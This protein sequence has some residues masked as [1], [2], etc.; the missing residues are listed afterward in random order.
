M[1]LSAYSLASGSSGNS[2]LVCNEET[3]ILIDAGLSGRELIL[4]MKSIGFDPQKL[5]AILIS[6]EHLDHIHGAGPLARKLKVPIVANAA[7]LS[8]MHS[9]IGE[10]DTIQQRTGSMVDL[11]G[12]LVK[13]FSIP[14]DAA[15]PVGFRFERGKDL[16]CSA[17]DIG[18]PTETLFRAM[19]GCQLIILE[20]NHDPSALDSG[21]YPERLKQRIRGPLGH[22][23]NFQAADLITRHVEEQ[24]PS[25][26][27][28]AH[29]SD[30]NNTPR[31][32][33]NTVD[34]VLNE[35]PRR[36]LARIQVALRSQVS[37]SWH[38]GAI[39]WQRSLF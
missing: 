38:S 20:A 11:N 22:L 21:P 24:N 25:C 10:T 33:L 26:F 37:A 34:A 18:E 32:A 16:I 15:D 5:C 7:T 1:G 14:H 27:W 8:A 3:G 6:H 17:T 39:T 9:H 35:S 2:I 13:S 36:S 12:I 19:A 31:L 4:R 23:S 29:L 28:L 30:K